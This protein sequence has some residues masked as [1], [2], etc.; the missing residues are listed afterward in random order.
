[1]PR[2]IARYSISYG[3]AGCYM[4]DSHDGPYV[5]ATRA[6]LA[7]IIRS[8]LETYGM[9][10]CLFREVRIRKLWSFIRRNG[11]SVAHFSLDHKGYSLAFHGLTAAECDAMEEESV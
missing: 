1:M 10:A 9:P 5:A 2:E 6:G 3:L 4:P 11:S 7:N 8:E